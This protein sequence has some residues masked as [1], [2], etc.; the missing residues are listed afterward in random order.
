MIPAIQGDAEM[1]GKRTSTG[2]IT[3]S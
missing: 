3:N 1:S 2:P